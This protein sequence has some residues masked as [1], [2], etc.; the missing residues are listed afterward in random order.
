V[1]HVA[2]SSVHGVWLTGSDDNSIKVW[3]QLGRQ[4]RHLQTDDAIS[5]LAVDLNFGHIL[6]ACN[7]ATH[8]LRVYV[9]GLAEPG[10]SGDAAVEHEPYELQSHLGHT[11]CIRRIVHIPEKAQYLTASWDCTLRT[12]RQA[13]GM[14]QGSAAV[15]RAHFRPASAA[16]PARARTATPSGGGGGGGGAEGE[17]A[18]PTF[19]DLNPLRM[20]KSLQKES[21]G[22]YGMA[23]GAG[24]LTGG[25]IVRA[26]GRGR[27]TDAR[28]KGRLA[29]AARALRCAL[30]G[31]SARFAHPPRC[32]HSLSLS[33]SAAFLPLALSRSRALALA[34]LLLLSPRLPSRLP[35]LDLPC[36]RARARSLGATR[37]SRARHS[38][39]T[40]T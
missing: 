9:P 3:S 27:A 12:W 10:A 36:S 40:G 30:G 6:A 4:L 39:T 1:V 7:D 24:S 25:M 31:G 21:F 38:M 32:A 28:S 35:T 19:A 17:R 2:W 15:G 14:R 5:A 33:C 11:D 8:A 13:A 22:A 37:A 34:L 26:R 29:V 16:G 23:G 18:A 20:P